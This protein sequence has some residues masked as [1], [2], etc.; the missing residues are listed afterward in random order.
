MARKLKVCLI[1]FIFIFL[2]LPCFFFGCNDNDDYLT[3]SNGD[4]SLSFDGYN[5]QYENSI[6]YIPETI[7]EKPVTEITAFDFKD[8]TGIVEIVLPNTIKKISAYAF[9]GLENLTTISF[10]GNEAP[11]LEGIGYGAFE[12]CENLTKFNSTSAGTLDMPASVEFVDCYAFY[13]TGF[14]TINLGANIDYIG[15]VAFSNIAGLTNISVS[16]NS[17]YFSNDGA[18]FNSDGCL[19]QYP[20]GKP[21]TSYE[22]PSSVSN[23]PIRCISQFAFMGE[24][25]LTTINL[26]NVIS[27]D[28]YAFKG[29]TSLATFTN[30][31]NIEYVR[32]FALDDTP[33]MQ[34]TGDF[35]ALGKV[36]CK[37]KGTASVLN[38]NDFPTG[39]TRI[40]SNAFCC[41]D[42]IEKIYLPNNIADI[43]NNAF[44][45]C[46]NL[47]EVIYYNAVLPS[48][49][50]SSFVALSNTFK[51]YC[52]KAL[53]DSLSSSNN[54]YNNWY[55]QREILSPISTEVYF[56]DID[57]HVTFY[58]GENIQLPTEELSDK[59]ILGWLRVNESTNETYGNYLTSSTWNETAPT[60]IYR[61]DA[62]IVENYTVNFFNGDE[63]IGAFN[64]STGDEFSI[65]QT[66]YTINGN[67]R[68]FTG[69]FKMHNC[70]YGNYY[71]SPIIDNV[72]VATFEGW[73][74]NGEM[75]S[76]SGEWGTYNK[77]ILNA[78]AVWAP[79][80]FSIVLSDGY[81]G[82]I[83]QE[84][85]N[86]FDGFTLPTLS[87]D[88]YE[89]KGWE[90]SDGF[91]YKGGTTFNPI[92]NT[93][94]IAK[95]KEIW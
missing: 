91:I 29:C 9:S 44:I 62:I 35:I 25:N 93:E 52:R 60:A 24:N 56:E 70:A 49:Q 19:M 14:T 88:G 21:D 95:W 67:T 94:L 85:V 3:T 90:T 30:A 86:F 82:N 40:S 5:G 26:N 8:K 7:N 53:I 89:F 36:L 39:V 16:G 33:I 45:D 59:Y 61:A 13:G 72:T 83:I 38:T 15:E 75:L 63:R 46:S 57:K 1:T 43:D 74:L 17:T 23:V 66:G 34:A 54:W 12:G 84:D 32:A 10:Y 77:P 22:I 4:G 51:F 18:L 50:N 37:Y 80:N 87:R 41:N 65:T 64:I 69:K 11:Q 2:V 31:I 28:S 58:Y 68:E 79:I 73:S 27:I 78:Y 55:N 47:E 71:G 42:Y 6:F 92:K 76:N 48:V 81:S 20:V